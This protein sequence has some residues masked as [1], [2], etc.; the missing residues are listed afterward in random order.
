M[1]PSLI[2]PDKVYGFL[3]YQA[4][5]TQKKRPK[6]EKGGI[7]KKGNILIEMTTIKLWTTKK[8]EVSWVLPVNK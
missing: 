3:Y 4:Y 8:K 2:T 7:S 5:R 1:E 6:T